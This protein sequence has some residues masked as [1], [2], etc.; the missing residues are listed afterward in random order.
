MWG[1]SKVLGFLFLSGIF[2]QSRQCIRLR[3]IFAQSTT[4]HQPPPAQKAAEIGGALPHNSCCS[5]ESM[6][7]DKSNIDIPSGKNFPCVE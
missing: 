2:G 5:P 7:T 3:A 1:T 6:S 4:H